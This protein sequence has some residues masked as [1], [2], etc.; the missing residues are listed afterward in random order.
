VI[1]P[2]AEFTVQPE[3]PALTTLYVI[4]PPPDPG[5]VTTAGVLGVTE[6]LPSEIVVF[7]GDQLI[8]WL[9]GGVPRT[10]CTFTM[11]PRGP[12]STVETVKLSISK[13]F[14]ENRTF[15]TST[16]PVTKRFM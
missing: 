11:S 10:F 3:V 8:T 16:D 9:A 15:R 13:L 6:G 7:V 5:V 12:D 1:T 14:P 2:V 4:A